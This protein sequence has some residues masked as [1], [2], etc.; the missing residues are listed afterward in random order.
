M[1]VPPRPIKPAKLH[2]L[3]TRAEPAQT[4]PTAHTRRASRRRGG[5]SPGRCGAGGIGWAQYPQSSEMDPTVARIVHGMVEEILETDGRVPLS[6]L[7]VE[8]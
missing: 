8:W 4:A 7:M 1:C 5:A 6:L 2:P 3:H